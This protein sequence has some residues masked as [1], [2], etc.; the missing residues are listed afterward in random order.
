LKKNKAR[1]GKRRSA[2]SVCKSLRLLGVN[3]A[4]LKSKLTTFKKVFSELKPS[5]FFIEE[6][7]YKDIGK[8]KFENFI[9]FELVRNKSQIYAP[10]K[11][12]GQSAVILEGQTPA[13]NTKETN[14]KVNIV[15]GRMG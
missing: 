15:F 8:L 4:R 14:K 10:R 2:K 6:S 7:K 13:L 1:R 9:V 12:H 11:N 5:V 3:S